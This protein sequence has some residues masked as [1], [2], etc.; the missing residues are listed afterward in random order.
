MT[1]RKVALFSLMLAAAAPC[2]AQTEPSAPSAAASPPA[3]ASSAAPA[4]A[5]SASSSAPASSSARATSAATDDP[6]PDLIKKA[7]RE[8]YK[9]EK[10]KNGET[11]FCHK[12]ADIG[13]RFETKKC[14]KPDEIQVVIDARQDQRNLL[15]QQGACTGASCSGR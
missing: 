2:M 7:H 9:P 10:Q 4:N 15:R 3:A 11:L 6:S 8:G 5:A 12:D 14:V 1:Y 13:T